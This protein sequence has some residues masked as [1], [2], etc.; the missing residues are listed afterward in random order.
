MLAGGESNLLKFEWCGKFKDLK[1]HVTNRMDNVLETQVI[2]AR[3]DVC[4]ELRRRQSSA[5]VLTPQ[6]FAHSN[7]CIRR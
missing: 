7:A 6:C 1:Q 5:C 4:L 2:L 3:G